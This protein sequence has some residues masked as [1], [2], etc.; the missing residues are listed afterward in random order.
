M[1]LC[2]FLTE[3]RNSNSVGF[4]LENLPSHLK[5]KL[6]KEGDFFHPQNAVLFSF[7]VTIE[8]NFRFV[9]IVV[10]ACK[11]KYPELHCT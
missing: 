5:L 4:N 7:Q 1:S 3:L 9:L 10:F 8:H 6:T 2:I 11:S